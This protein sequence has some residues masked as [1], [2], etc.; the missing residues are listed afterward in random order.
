MTCKSR[1]EADVRHDDV[2]V[3][4]RV[5]SGAV[6]VASFHPVI[7]PVFWAY[8]DGADCNS[9]DYYGLTT[10]IDDA[11]RFRPGE[12]GIASFLNRIWW[13]NHEEDDAEIKGPDSG[14]TLIYP[15]EVPTG[16]FEWLAR[17][18]GTTADAIARWFNSALWVEYAAPAK[19]LFLKDFN[20]F[21]GYL[22]EWTAYPQHALTFSRSELDD[23]DDMDVELARG[24]GK[25]VPLSSASD[26]PSIRRLEQH[27]N[28][29]LEAD[30]A[31]TM[32]RLLP[33]YGAFRFE[34]RSLAFRHAVQAGREHARCAADTPVSGHIAAFAELRS[35]F[36]MGLALERHF[37][38]QTQ[39]ERAGQPANLPAD[40]HAGSAPGMGMQ[41]TDGGEHV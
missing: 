7:G 25:F 1:S 16:C 10:D 13:D 19:T 27:I 35:A 34:W 33:Q 38:S 18:A 31:W 2:F 40:D 3:L 32:H 41:L 39:Q 29:A 30:V 20:G 22:P 36:D 37:A 28:H 4:R 24:L 6:V 17:H 21:V 11:N 9:D 5:M 12:V 23:E 26:I 15:I 8:A 14:E